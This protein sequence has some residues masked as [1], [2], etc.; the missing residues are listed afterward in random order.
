MSGSLRGA[1]SHIAWGSLWGWCY[2]CN[3]EPILKDICFQFQDVLPIQVSP[4]HYVPITFLCL[5]P[6]CVI[7]LSGF[8]VGNALHCPSESIEVLTLFQPYLMHPFC[9]DNNYFLFCWCL[10]VQEVILSLL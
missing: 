4:R 6:F 8:I 2:G 10:D 3:D 9:F 1:A 5:N 7:L